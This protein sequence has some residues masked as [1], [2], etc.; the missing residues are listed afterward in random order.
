VPS[1][2]LTMTVT[3]PRNKSQGAPGQKRQHAHVRQSS[4]L[5]P[6]AV[7]RAG[8]HAGQTKTFRTCAAAP[9]ERWKNCRC[10]TDSGGS[11]AMITIGTP[12]GRYSIPLLRPFTSAVHLGQ[13]IAPGPRHTR[14]GGWGRSPTAAPN[15]FACV[16]ISPSA[17]AECAAWPRPSSASRERAGAD[18]SLTKPQ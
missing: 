14:L 12:A 9:G 10:A 1:C 8:P 11:R 15:G 17:R 2:S 3:A 4:E 18:R 6:N 13:I 7:P 5:P 16:A